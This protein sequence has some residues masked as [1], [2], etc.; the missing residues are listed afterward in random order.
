MRAITFLI[1][2]GCVFYPHF[3]DAS[4]LVIQTKTPPGRNA[5]ENIRAPNEPNEPN[6]NV[7]KAPGYLRWH[8]LETSLGGFKV[9]ITARKIVAT[10][11]GQP[12]FVYAPKKLIAQAEPS[13]SRPY[14]II[15]LGDEKKLEQARAEVGGDHVMAWAYATGIRI[16][17]IKRKRILNPKTEIS[18]WNNMPWSPD[19]RY[20]AFTTTTHGPI[21]LFDA[22]DFRKGY[23]PV[24]IQ[25][26]K[27]CALALSF[28]AWISNTKF[29]FSGSACATSFYDY[30]YDIVTGKSILL[31]ERHYHIK[32]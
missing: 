8:T 1:F 21:H 19:G 29:S 25:P 7:V 5:V 13:S 23:K 24:K 26:G 18:F 17:D 31:S 14:I 2:F 4:G 27:G 10:H 16:I 22:D 32:H 15:L 3:S 20:A 11:R 9:K 12:W 30:A 28:G 6:E